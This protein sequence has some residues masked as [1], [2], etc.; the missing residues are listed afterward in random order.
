M[1]DLLFN[2]FIFIFDFLAFERG[3]TA[4]LHIKDGLGLEFGQFEAFHQAFFGDVGIRG[5]ADG[6]DD[7][8]QVVQG[9]GEA[10][11]DMCACAGFIQVE[12]GTAG[13]ERSGGVR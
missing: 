1:G 3:Q 10:I 9:D 13:D 12:L 2:L 6:L 4:Q 8:I 7:G 11:Q 5:F